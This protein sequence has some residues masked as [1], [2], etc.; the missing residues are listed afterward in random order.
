ML[1]RDVPLS[2]QPWRKVGN[3]SAHCFN[4]AEPAPCPALLSL[5]FFFASPKRAEGLVERR[6]EPSHGMTGHVSSV[7]TAGPTFCETMAKAADVHE[8]CRWSGS[9]AMHRTMKGFLGGRGVCERERCQ[10]PKEQPS[11]RSLSMSRIDFE[12]ISVI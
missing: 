11:R 12:L 1:C 8:W 6:R 2:K 10:R 4:A 5:C 7:C 9:Q 3:G